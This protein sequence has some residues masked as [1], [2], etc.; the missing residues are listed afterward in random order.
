MPE[1]LVN[2]TETA[3]Q[4]QDT[5]A[6]EVTQ[7]QSAEQTNVDATTPKTY[8]EEDFNAAIEAKLTEERGKLQKQTEELERRSK[9]TLEERE[10]EI[11]ERE[12]T[13]KIAEMK[14]D[15]IIR[16]N[17]SQIPHEFL[18]IINFKDETENVLK[19]IEKVE[20]VFGEAVNKAVNMRLRGTTP[21]G[22]GQNNVV[23][24]PFVQ[25]LK[26]QKNFLK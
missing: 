11:L 8:T 6:A 13:L 24:D 21:T 16:F 7:A 4:A 1:E 17:K 3:G 18:D 25:G 5:R 14:A 10:K 15:T 2:G 22:G 23:D 19:N 9:M 26:G 20:N 12:K